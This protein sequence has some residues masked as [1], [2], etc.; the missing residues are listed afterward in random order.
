[1][2][3]K[4]GITLVALIITII[5]LLILAGVVIS[6]T[7]GNDGIIGKAQ[8]AVDAYKNAQEKEEQI[9]N[10]TLEYMNGEYTV[11]TGTSSGGANSGSGTGGN[12]PI[13]EFYPVINSVTSNSIEVTVPDN[14]ANN[15]DLV[16]YMYLLENEVKELTKEKT[17]TF[18]NLENDHKYN[19]K[20][21]C[22]DKNGNIK[23]SLNKEQ[24][25][26]NATYL[27]QNGNTTLTYITQA[28]IDPGTISNSD[29]YMS[30]SGSDSRGDWTVY[31]HFDTE[32]IDLTNINCIY[33]HFYD[34]NTSNEDMTL[35]IS[36]FKTINN[37]YTIPTDCFAIDKKAN[38]KITNGD[39]VL[40]LDTSELTGEYNLSFGGITSK[41]Y[42]GDIS[43]SSNA[44]TGSLS[45]K[46]DSVWY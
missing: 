13:A 31:P 23:S 24:K 36:A 35:Y 4:R 17:Y 9:L 41:D 37:S 1:M 40:Q 6:M 19:I 30:A 46:I 25:T 5:V 15:R 29:G 14:I 26:P 44:Y 11:G 21:Y 2:K 42:N 22:V 8:G 28:G 32:K 20:I 43:S 45:Y 10:Q 16:G 27:Y 3:N 12:I 33:I 7:V 39:F 38:E 34:V 18:R